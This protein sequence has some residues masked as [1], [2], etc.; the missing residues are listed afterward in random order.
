MLVNPLP[1]QTV[2]DPAP[3]PRRRD[4]TR[5]E[6]KKGPDCSPERFPSRA[7]QGR[8]CAEEPKVG[9]QEVNRYA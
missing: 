7:S 5:V 9:K 6:R 3:K 4:W 1:I 2:K 8:F